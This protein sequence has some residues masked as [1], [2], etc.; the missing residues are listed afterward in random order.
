M[1]QFETQCLPI[2]LHKPVFKMLSRVL[3]LQASACYETRIFLSISRKISFFVPS[4][5][6]R[7]QF[8]LINRNYSKQLICINTKDMNTHTNI[9][10]TRENVH[11]DKKQ[12]HTLSHTSNVY[13]H[14]L[15]DDTRKSLFMINQI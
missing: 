11:A 8:S 10:N 13:I 7:V 14:N 6:K 3:D 9:H 1:F 12:R 2:F 4:E 15:V 5:R